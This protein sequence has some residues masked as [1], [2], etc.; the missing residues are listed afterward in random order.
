MRPIGPIYLALNENVKIHRFDVYFVIS[1]LQAPL[2]IK[3]IHGG[4]SESSS[5]RWVTGD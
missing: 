4:L 5:S 3:T 1:L 2:Y